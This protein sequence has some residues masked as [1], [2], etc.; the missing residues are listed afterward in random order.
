MLKRSGLVTSIK[1]AQGGYQLTRAPKE[2]TVFDVLSAIETSLFEKPEETVGEKAPA[3]EAAMQSAAFGPLNDIIEKTLK[4]I[5]IHDLI[6]ETEKHTED[7][8]YMFFI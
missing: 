7:T 3:I 2:I 5:T 1:G 6:S 8:G 4:Q